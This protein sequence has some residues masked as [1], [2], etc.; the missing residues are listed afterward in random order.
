M[1]QVRVLMVEDNE[2]DAVLIQRELMRLSPQPAVQHVRTEAAFVAALAHGSPPHVI[3]CDH[4]IP[5]FGGAHALEL[6]QRA[7]PDVPFILVT[8]SLDEETAVSYLKNG[9]A[10]YIL[11]D[12]VV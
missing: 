11:K 12:R 3:L 4:N 5:G 2:T 6:A 1:E 10:D 8:G 7:M 9:A